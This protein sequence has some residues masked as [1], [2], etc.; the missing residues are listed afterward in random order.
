M[1][2]VRQWPTLC[3][4]FKGEFILYVILVIVGIGVFKEKEINNSI[5]LYLP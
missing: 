4:P 1:A 3:Y 2:V 5:T